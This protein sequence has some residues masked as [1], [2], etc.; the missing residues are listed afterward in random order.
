MGGLSA[1]MADGQEAGRQEAGP[2]AAW[3]ALE[4]QIERSAD[5]LLHAGA[6]ERDGR[7][8]LFP[9]VSGVGKS[10]MTAACLSCGFGYLSDEA[11]AVDLGSGHITGMPRSLMLTPWAVRALGMDERAGT[12]VGKVAVPVDAFGSEPVSGPLPV[13]HVVIIERGAE[14]TSVE[15][16]PAGEILTQVLKASFNHYMHG[17]RAWEAAA[18]LAQEAQG[19]RLASADPRSA[20]TAVADLFPPR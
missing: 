12:G 17:A 14:V 5:L 4:A 20:A 16:V 1:R 10:T 3:P 8:V 2:H 7:A 6:V 9:G 19:W 11:V 18:R 13:A 15:R